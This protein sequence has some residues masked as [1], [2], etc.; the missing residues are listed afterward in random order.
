MSEQ[1]TVVVQEP[2][3]NQRRLLLIV[4][5][6]VVVLA[7]LWLFVLAPLLAGDDEEPEE[8]AAVVP[9]ETEAPELAQATPS[10]EVTGDAEQLPVETFEVFLARDPFRPVRAAP[11]AGGETTGGGTTAG[12][13]TGAPTTG[14]APTPGAPTPGGPTPGPPTQG[15]GE[16]TRV[17]GREVALIDVFV[18]DGVERA[19]VQVDGTAY[20]VGEGDTFA[21]NFRVLSID[22]PCVTL[23]FGDDAFTL[24]EGDRVLK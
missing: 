20:E 22:P 5:G 2:P 14:G 1:E 12:A 15:G 17:E 9:E 7:L 8:P 3:A 21:E 4:L 11:D 16:S 23:L 18:Q 24:C 19:V 10:P 6:V 13:T